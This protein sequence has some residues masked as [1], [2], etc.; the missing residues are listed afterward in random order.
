MQEMV[1]SMARTNLQRN[2]S[3][4]SQAD[5]DIRLHGYD[6]SWANSRK[7][8]KQLKKDNIELSLFEGELQRTAQAE[9]VKRQV[10]CETSI[11]TS[12]PYWVIKGKFLCS[13]RHRFIGLTKSNF[14]QIFLSIFVV[15]DALLVLVEIVLELQSMRS[16]KMLLQQKI[17]T[18]IFYLNY[19]KRSCFDTDS[20][21]NTCQ[22][23]RPEQP[24]LRRR[25]SLEGAAAGL[26]GGLWHHSKD[27]NEITKTV[28][29]C[30]YFFDQRFKSSTGG[31]INCTGE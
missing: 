18:A 11:M 14:F 21:S 4:E 22:W 15:L 17:Q 13:W 16:F 12:Q 26:H 9:T 7:F 1:K 8:M 19:Y 23:P 24:H 29:K 5:D 20:E 2:G 25:R 28:K 31:Q 10:N 27:N 3:E 6:M 30:L